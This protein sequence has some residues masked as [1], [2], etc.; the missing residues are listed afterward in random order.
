MVV[1]R[2]RNTCRIV[3]VDLVFRLQM[4]FSNVI[5]DL[6]ISR[7][8]FAF[9]LS[10]AKVSTGFINLFFYGFGIRCC[11]ATMSRPSSN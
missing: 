5:V 11:V 4:V 7:R 6:T 8:S 2:I 1:C 9:C 3:P 10:R